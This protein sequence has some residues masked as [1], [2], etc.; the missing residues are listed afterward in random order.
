MLVKH[1]INVYVEKPMARS[2]H[3]IEILMQAAKKIRRSSKMGNQGHS[4]ANYFQFKAW[5]RGGHY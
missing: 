1:G 2:F 3:Q 4:E 5:K